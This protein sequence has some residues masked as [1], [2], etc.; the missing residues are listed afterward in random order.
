LSKWVVGLRR[1]IGSC[2]E[3]GGDARGDC[4]RDGEVQ[5]SRKCQECNGGRGEDRSTQHRIGKLG[6]RLTHEEEGDHELEAKPGR[7]ARA[8]R[9]ADA[10][11]GEPGHPEQDRAAEVVSVRPTAVDQPRAAVEPDRKRR[12]DKEIGGHEPPPPRCAAPIAGHRRGV[13]DEPDVDD[14]CGGHHDDCGSPGIEH[15]D[16][17]HL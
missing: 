15:L 1:H 14:Q 17:R 5:R 13:E 11:S 8:D 2:G 3:T 10:D 9:C 4:Q 7:Q 16:R 6:D 12:I